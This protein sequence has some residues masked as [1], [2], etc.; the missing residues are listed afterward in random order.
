MGKVVVSGIRTFGVILLLIHELLGEIGY[1]LSVSLFSLLNG[2]S[3]SMHFIRWL[4]LKKIN[5]KHSKC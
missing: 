1:L 4:G 3:K 5:I 2:F